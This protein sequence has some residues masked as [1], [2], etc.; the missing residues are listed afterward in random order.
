MRST[1]AA[2]AGLLALLILMQSFSAAANAV[3]I[4]GFAQ[5]NYAARVSGAPCP[6]SGPC[7][8]LLGDERF[9]LKAE[10]ASEQGRSSFAAKVDL[11]QDALQDRSGIEVR[12]VFVDLTGK[13]AALRVGR[14]IVTWGVGDLLFANDVFP[15]DW[16]ALFTG[17]PMEYLKVGSDALKL[18]LHPGGIEAEIVV[19]P[20]FQPDRY[21]TGDRLLLPDPFPPGLPRLEEKKRRSL[22]NVELAGK[23]S[24]YVSDWSL[25]LYGARTFYRSPAMALDDPAT[26]S[27]VRTFYPRLN[28]CGASA[29]GSLLGGVVGLEGAYLDAED[30]RAGTNPAV[31][32][33]MVKMLA[34]YSYPVWRDAT[35]G[36]QGYSEWLLDYGA[37][38]ATLPVG[39]PPRHE[40]R[41]LATARLTQ[42][43]WNQTLTGNLF[44]FWGVT[45]HDGYLIPSARYAATDNVWV[46]VGGNLFVGRESHTMFGALDRN[47]NVY[48][49]VRY[50]F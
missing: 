7:D 28:T 34:G 14:Q 4:G 43:L 12:E 50:S 36:L 2:R 21:P 11:F 30:D 47:D 13:R 46:E 5:V 20:F 42:L 24:R 44:A 16:V 38:Q 9:Q 15:K 10:G 32:N 29:A 35:L 17:R 23:L 1:L 18:D 33:S 25:S 22:E 8:F 39:F 49:T 41:W 26:P 31:E 3:D 48:A 45:D 6:P 40:R 27:V 19:L 37:Y